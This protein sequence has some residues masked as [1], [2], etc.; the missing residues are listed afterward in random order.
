MTTQIVGIRAVDTTNLDPAITKWD[1]TTAAA[2]GTTPTLGTHEKVA[3]ESSAKDGSKQCCSTAHFDGKLYAL[4]GDSV[5]ESSDGS[6]WTASTLLNG[7]PMNINAYHY[8]SS[9]AIAWQP[10]FFVHYGSVV[11]DSQVTSRLFL[12][13][14]DG[15][16]YKRI[17]FWY[18]EAG[19]AGWTAYHQNINF[20][21]D[22][23][24]FGG[25]LNTSYGQRYAKGP[26]SLRVIEG[27]VWMGS[28]Y[29]DQENKDQILVYDPSDKTTEF[30]PAGGTATD[31]AQLSIAS[32]ISWKGEVYWA[33]MKDSET[34][35]ALYKYNAGASSHVVDLA[36]VGDHNFRNMGHPVWVDPATNDLIVLYMHGDWASAGQYK[37]LRIANAD[38]TVT[39]ITST[40][41]PAE[42]T[43]A[44]P[45][46]DDKFWLWVDAEAGSGTT[47]RTPTVKMIY[48]ASDHNTSYDN[49]EVP[50]YEWT[51]NGV[52][53]AM[54]AVEGSSGVHNGSEQEN[55]S[56]LRTWNTSQAKAVITETTKGANKYTIKCKLYVAPGGS[57]TTGWK[58][59]L[60]Y[61][62]ASEP[63]A[64]TQG[65]LT[66]T[67]TQANNASESRNGNIIEN[68]T[69]HATAP[70]ELTFEWDLSSGTPADSEKV[71]IVLY[72]H[73]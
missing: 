43:T 7:D 46:Q 53:S 11:G 70:D 4:F 6:T 33:A 71:S 24:T 50:C 56:G 22:A 1:G 63:Y 9:S 19:D 10:G 40:V 41:L 42:F 34:Q 64:V 60:Y 3:S 21:G 44:R 18:K 28:V 36:T 49:G 59:S 13:A 35:L 55:C 68:V 20:S 15:N 69:A 23:V 16:D 25:A 32:P 57:T 12:C 8:S 54:T 45:R 48:Q 72:A 66:G 38:H 65:T 52:G 39:D 51:W 27:R 14:S 73:Q 67:P 17:Q 2:L 29:N 62:R 37:A 31:T 5:Y 26:Q 47:T 30:F 58:V 61:R